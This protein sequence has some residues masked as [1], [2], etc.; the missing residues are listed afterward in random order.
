MPRLHNQCLLLGHPRQILQSQPVLRPV[1]KHRSVSPVG[2]QLVGEL[3]H[4]GVE[5]VHDVVDY[6]GS[7]LRLAGVGADRVRSHPE[8]RG[9]E[10]VHVDVAVVLSQLMVTCSYCMKS[11]ASYWCHFFGK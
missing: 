5:V 7:L 2:D 9:T 3:C 10:S 8:A 1:L 6:G 11:E 4:V